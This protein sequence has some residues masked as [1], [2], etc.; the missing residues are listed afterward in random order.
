MTLP[1]EVGHNLRGTQ[2]RTIHVCNI[3]IVLTQ[4]IDPGCP[5]AYTVD[6]RLWQMCSN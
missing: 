5:M 6:Y 3:H 4:Q 1:E 2:M